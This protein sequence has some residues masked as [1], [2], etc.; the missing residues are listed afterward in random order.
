M[1]RI[2][3]SLWIPQFFGVLLA[4]TTFYQ[5][6]CLLGE[7]INFGSALNGGPHNRNLCI[8]MMMP[9][10]WFCCMQSTMFLVLSLDTL[11]SVLCPLKHK[12]TRLWIYVSIVSIPPIAYAALIVSLNSVEILYGESHNNTV[13]ICNPPLSMDPKIAN[14]WINWNG[15]SNLGVLCVHFTVYLIVTKKEKE[16]V[17]LGRVVKDTTD[18]HNFENG[19]EERL[20]L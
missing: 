13:I 16:N 4:L 5:T 9:Y 19:D 1:A 17:Q 2:C 7:L 12:V 6:L 11:F 20:Y 18:K 15:F 14:F 10:I 3:T 8:L